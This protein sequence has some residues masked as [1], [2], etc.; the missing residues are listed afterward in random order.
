M[1]YTCNEERETC[2]RIEIPNGEAK[3]IGRRRWL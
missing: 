3:K 1:E 2:N